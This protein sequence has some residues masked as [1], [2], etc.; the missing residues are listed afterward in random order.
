ME[1]IV[2]KEP[3]KRKMKLSNYAMLTTH[4]INLIV[5]VFVSTFLVSYIYSISNN[6]II[7]I[8]L[9]YCFNYLCMGVSYY[10]ISMFLD[11][12]NRVTFY[13]I[14]IV[15][16]TIFIMCVVFL[17]RK[18]AELVILAGLLHGFSEACYWSS[19]NIMKN[20]LVPNS[21][22][23]S[24]ASLQI[25]I[26]KVV[27]IVIPIILGKIIDADSFKTSAII[28]LCVAVI[29]MVFSFLIKSK[30]PEN[31]SF[32]M[33]EFISDI[34]QLGEKKSLVTDIIIYGGVYGVITMI[35]PLN[36]I[37]IM[38]SFNSNFSLGLITS[39]FSAASMVFLFIIKRF[40]KTGKRTLLYILVSVF[41]M[42][43]VLMV[44]IFT[45]KI[46][47]VIYMLVYN[48]CTV[49]HAY[50]YDVHRNR[51]LKRFSMY[52][53][54][55]EFQCCIECM[56]E[57]ARAFTFLV[58]II[59]GVIVGVSGM[60]VATKVLLV[61]SMTMLPIFNIGLLFYERRLKKFNLI[62]EN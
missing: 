31:S 32:N 28:V 19:Y 14:A 12:T 9:F 57:V 39:L 24:Y 29:E 45:N 49:S 20:E 4:G 36:T 8:G 27:N 48:I 34:K 44:V 5:S 18:L 54:I 33:R 58:M 1:E 35:A 7:N 23:G 41:S 52:D 55:A 61:V 11:K 22:M 42:L 25:V 6:Y 17:G 15:I 62:E 10:I 38:L 51:V 37:L 59:V 30:R 43:S 13:R 3:Q 53:D 46:I 56:M 26:D 21:C 60:A 40:T 47:L 2:T 50:N 16:R